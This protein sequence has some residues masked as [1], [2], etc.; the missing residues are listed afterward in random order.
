MLIVELDLISVF[1]ITVLGISVVL[2]LTQ[3]GILCVGVI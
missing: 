2:E 3:R 1:H